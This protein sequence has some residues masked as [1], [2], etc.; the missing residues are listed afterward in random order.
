MKVQ[1]FIIFFVSF[2]STSTED[3]LSLSWF[4]A[5]EGSVVLDYLNLKYMML[6]FYVNF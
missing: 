1:K 5:C 4:S 2:F 3:E 6:C